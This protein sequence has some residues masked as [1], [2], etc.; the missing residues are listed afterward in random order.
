M[1]G[2]PNFPVMLY[3]P[4]HRTKAS[5]WV[6]KCNRQ[7]RFG[8]RCS[9]TPVG[10]SQITKDNRWGGRQIWKRC[11]L[12]ENLFWC[13]FVFCHNSDGNWS[14]VRLLF[15]MYE[16]CKLFYLIWHYLGRTLNKKRAKVCRFRPVKCQ[17]CLLATTEDWPTTVNVLRK[18][19]F[20]ACLSSIGSNAGKSDIF[21]F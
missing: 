3:K 12:W 18:N 15:Y 7:F 1:F 14:S 16:I 2:K 9:Q 4:T 10:Q 17:G 21:I 20:L 11:H 6:P 19:P 5:M 13:S 8:R